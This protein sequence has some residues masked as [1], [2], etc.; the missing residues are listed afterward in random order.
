MRTLL[1]ALAGLMLAMPAAGDGDAA[2]PDDQGL[3]G[4][5]SVALDSNRAADD[6]LWRI[7]RAK[8]PQGTMVLIR[9]ESAVPLLVSFDSENKP[10][11][12]G[13]PIPPGETCEQRCDY[14]RTIYDV[15]LIT[16][17]GERVLDT[18]LHCGDSVIAQSPQ[19]T[20]TLRR[21][22]AINE[23]WASSPGESVAEPKSLNVG[24]H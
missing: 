21:V 22:E 9:N 7:R 3:F 20:G 6:Q 15:A 14:G 12:S 16:E 4:A 24:G 19:W 8:N 13:D 5:M 18:R 2:V 23:A 17:R 10:A 1:F 11:F